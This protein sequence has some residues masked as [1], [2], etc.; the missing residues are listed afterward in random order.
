MSGDLRF[1]GVSLDCADPAELAHFYLRLLGGRVL[2][3]RPNSVGVQ[4]AGQLRTYTRDAESSRPGVHS[5]QSGYT[6]VDFFQQMQPT[7]WKT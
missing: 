5:T 7:E 6:S 2:W 1:V 4:L 3:S